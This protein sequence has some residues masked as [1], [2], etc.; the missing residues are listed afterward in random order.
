MPLNLANHEA[1]AKAAVKRFWTGRTAATD[2]QSATGKLDQG[3][4]GAVTGGNSLG[5]CHLPGE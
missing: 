2:T 3:E 4:R 5:R 1:K